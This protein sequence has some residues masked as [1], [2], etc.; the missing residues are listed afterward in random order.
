MRLCVRRKG[1]RTQSPGLRAVRA[2]RGWRDRRHTGPRVRV[3]ETRRARE[4]VS[5]GGGLQYEEPTPAAA[6][7]PRSAPL[8]FPP[9]PPSRHVPAR[10]RACRV[11]SFPKARLSLTHRHPRAQPV[12]TAVVAFCT[13]CRPSAVT[14]SSGAC[15]VPHQKRCPSGAA[16]VVAVGGTCTRQCMVPGHGPSGVARG[17]RPAQ[18]PLST[19]ANQPADQPT[20]QPRRGHVGVIGQDGRSHWSSHPVPATISGISPP[21]PPPPP[22][23]PPHNFGV[24]PSSSSSATT[25]TA[26]PTADMVATDDTANTATNAA[27]TTI[28]ARGRREPVN[29]PLY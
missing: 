17:R 4:R 19:A 21:P 22:S 3:L 9:A 12:H 24:S 13:R 7:A 16:V 6:P 20:N 27:I 29:V 23:P 18:L 28:A 10:P 11:R 15:L 14:P 5:P 26:A 8:R 1:G 25:P 2:V